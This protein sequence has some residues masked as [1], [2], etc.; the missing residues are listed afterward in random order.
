MRAVYMCGLA[1]VLVACGSSP[2]SV[3]DAG[4]TDDA[5]LADDAATDD[6]DLAAFPALKPDMPRVVSGGGPV[7]KTPRVTPVYFP[8]FDYVADMTDFSDKL[9][10][11]K[12]WAALGEYGVGQLTMNAPVL[13]TNDLIV[14]ADIAT[15]TDEQIQAWLISRFDGTHPEFG[16]TADP[17]SVYTLF[18]P[19]QTT[20][21]LGSGGG[22]SCQSFGGYH[23]D[24]TIAG[25]LIP[26]AVI[27]ECN[28]FGSLKNLDSVTTT[29]SHEISEASTD[30][31][32]MD[33]AAYAQVDG[34]HLAWEFFLG[35]GEVGDM[36]AQFSSSFYKPDDLLYIVQ[37]NWS[38]AQ[39]KAGH[40][41]CQPL[42]DPGQVYFN[43]SPTFPDKISTRGVF[44]K[45]VKVPVGTSKTIPLALYSDGPTNGP[46]TVTASAL[47]RGG[48]GGGGD[49]GASTGP[50]TLSLD[51]STGVNGDIINLTITAKTAITSTS[52]AVTILVTS[53][54][55]TRKNTWVGLVGN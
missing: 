23:S 10:G 54:L 39:A 47:G 32:P 20:I 42:V 11:S 12:Y 8:G 18:Y 44:T 50:V 22:T 3:A 19:P 5:G 34:D 43:A 33:K 7:L 29:T 25:Q 24:V 6:A 46:W 35:G 28:S 17:N 13:L 49:G 9:G 2:G 36:C 55:G 21:S 16:T 27:P 53:Q 14:P 30:P 37:R 31:Y 15:I 40:D 38:N 4:P 26:Y 48:S 45:G 41:P 51:K 52:A 1:S